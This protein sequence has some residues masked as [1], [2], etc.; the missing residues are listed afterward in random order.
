V[1]K[2]DKYTRCSEKKIL[3]IRVFSILMIISTTVLC[4]WRF[5]YLQDKSETEGDKDW[6][7]FAKGL[8]KW[9]LG[10]S[11]AMLFTIFLVYMWLICSL[12]TKESLMSSKLGHDYNVYSSEKTVLVLICALFMLSYLIDCIYNHFGLQTFFENEC[13]DKNDGTKGKHQC[14]YF[15][16]LLIV[17]SYYIVDVLPIAV[18]LFVHWSNFRLPSV[19]KKSDTALKQKRE[20]IEDIST[21][22]KLYEST[23]SAM[24][25]SV[26]ASALVFDSAFN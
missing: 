17:E 24:M 19:S 7:E 8:T 2:I 11:L 21:G 23:D 4:F 12:H 1:Q 22:D 13:F 15:S 18:I 16:F 3:V 9:F 14:N 6:N 25:Q 10:F 26:A 5:T 20:N